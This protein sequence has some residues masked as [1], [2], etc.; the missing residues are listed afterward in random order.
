M[1]NRILMLAVALTACTKQPNACTTDSDCTNPAYPF[2]DVDG[3]FAVSGNEKNT[4]TIVPPDCPVERC[5]CAPGA[6]S[7]SGDTLSTCDPGGA[8]QTMTA[9]V[10]GCATDGTRCQSFEPTNGLGPA[11]VAAAAEPPIQ[12]PSG[13][14][15]DTDTGAVT[16]SASLPIQVRSLLVTQGTSSIRVFIGRSAAL[17]DVTVTGASAFAIVASDTID[18]TGTIT[19]KGTFTTAGPGAVETGACA[20]EAGEP[21]GGGGGNATAGGN[22]AKYSALAMPAHGGMPLTSFEP[23]AG[24]CRGG[25]HTDSGSTLALGGGGGAVQLVAGAAI[26]ITGSIDV[27]GGGGFPGG[28]GG[29]GGMIILQAPEVV[30]TGGVYANGG[31]GGACDAA[32]ADGTTDLTPAAGAGPCGGTISNH[33]AGGAGGTVSAPATAGSVGLSGAAGGGGAVGRLQVMN[34]D[35]VFDPT[36]GTI[37]AALATAPLQAM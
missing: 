33:Q 9:C 8:S 23:L 21:G 32:G 28:G 29:S 35:G 20:G 6:T 12:L 31:G 34:L 7:C 30:V 24:G 18:I 26:A 25:A 4:C 11:L 27:G 15:V 19:A 2:C 1:T 13:A 17:G 5:G 14:H 3:E 36:T 22:G 16:D 10:L 37:S